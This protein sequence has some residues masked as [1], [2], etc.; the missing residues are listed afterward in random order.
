[1]TGASRPACEREATTHF[2][3]GLRIGILT[4]AVTVLLLLRML[5]SPAENPFR[6]QIVHSRH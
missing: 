6:V 4:L 1:M 2:L 5:S 3:F